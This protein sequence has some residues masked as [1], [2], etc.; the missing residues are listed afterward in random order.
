MTEEKIPNY[1]RELR[2]LSLQPI[3]TNLYSPPKH[4]CMKHEMQQENHSIFEKHVY[5]GNTF[6]GQP[7]LHTHCHKLALKP[8]IPSANIKH[9]PNLF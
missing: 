5:K 8:I 4:H 3:S 6:I 1:K 7:V 9:I 2:E